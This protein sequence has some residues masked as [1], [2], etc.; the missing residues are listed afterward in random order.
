MSLKKQIG[1]V[2]RP[3]PIKP[4]RQPKPYTRP[5]FTVF[6][7]DAMQAEKL[8][9]ALRESSDSVASRLIAQ[10]VSGGKA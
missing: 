2:A 4:D 1:E 9:G 6:R 10:V 7:P 5:E 8:T 3:L